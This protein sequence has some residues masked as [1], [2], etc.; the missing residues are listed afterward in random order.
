MEGSGAKADPLP[1]MRQ[2]ARSGD[3]D[4]GDL[5]GLLA[6]VAQGDQRAFARLY[7]ATSPKLYGVALRILRDEAA[8]QDCLQE[9]YVRVWHHAAR[10]S[11]ERGKAMTWLVVIVRRLALDRIRSRRREEPG[12]TESDLEHLLDAAAAEQEPA[13]L[14]DP[15]RSAALAS[16]LEWLGERQRQAVRLAYMEGLSHPELAER[17]GVPLGTVKTWVRRG[18]IQLRECLE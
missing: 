5:V 6:G 2:R 9:A 8:A 7:A 10:Y 17:L 11:P 13:E 18:L 4:S 14:P 1:V 16:C 15:Y 12:A 3:N